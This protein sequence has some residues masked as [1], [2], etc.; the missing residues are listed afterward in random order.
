MGCISEETFL[1]MLFCHLCRYS[2]PGKERGVR[3][4]SLK[5]CSTFQL[6]DLIWKGFKPYS[7][8]YYSLMASVP[9]SSAFN[10]SS[11]TLQI[12]EWSRVSR[13]GEVSFWRHQWYILSVVGE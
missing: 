12:I 1:H 13:P 11:K 8:L 9:I 4:A 2:S 6:R 3:Q 10:P 5:Y 7:R